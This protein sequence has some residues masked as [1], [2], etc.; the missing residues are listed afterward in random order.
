MRVLVVDDDEDIRALLVLKLTQA[1]YDTGAAEDGAIALR[2]VAVERPDL[3]IFDL[4]MPEMSGYDVLRELRSNAETREL[5]VLLLS[6]K[7]QQGDF[8]LGFDLGA[9]DY[10]VKPFGPKALIGRV[11]AILGSP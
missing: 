6:A 9:N 4:M 1:G 8:E 11:Q 10:V 7:S 3:V 5:P 2:E